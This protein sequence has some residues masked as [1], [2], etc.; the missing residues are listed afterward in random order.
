MNSLS[1]SSSAEWITI[2]AMPMRTDSPACGKSVKAA[3][4]PDGPSERRPSV[5]AQRMRQSELASCCNANEHSLLALLIHD[6]S[7]ACLFDQD[8]RDRSRR[9][10]ASS[11]AER[12]AMTAARRICSSRCSSSGMI[13]AS[14]SGGKSF[15]A[16]AA[17]SAGNSNPSDFLASTSRIGSRTTLASVSAAHSRNH[18]LML[19]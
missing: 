11:D 10:G 13:E 16:A 15:R 2:R 19:S 17:S 12:Q 9:T 1:R 18:F 6:L 14:R 4:T 8:R 7:E 5:A 3:R